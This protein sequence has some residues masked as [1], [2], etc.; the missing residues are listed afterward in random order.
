MILCIDPDEDARAATVRAFTEAGFEA[1]GVASAADARQSLRERGAVDALV[2][3]YDL[4]DGTGLELVNDSRELS[5]DTAC[6]LFTAVSLDDIDTEA[7]GGAVADYVSKDDPDARTEV[8]DRVEQSVAF[9]TQTS[10]PLPENE[11]ARVA[12][13]ERYAVDP[14]ALGG[15]IDRLAELATALF[16][17]DS[18]TVGVLDAHEQRF[19]SCHG[20]SFDTTDREETVCTYAILDDEVTV[21]EDTRDDPRFGDNEGLAAA[22]IRF[23]ASAPLVTPEGH[24]IGTFCIYDSEPRE[25]SEQDRHHLQ[26]FASEVM[27]QLTLRRRLQN[28]DEPDD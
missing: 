11:P 24:R 4:P 2:A 20:V 18:A 9:Q 26:L 17:V 6:V 23:Y 14:A 16:G 25:V 27:E 13:L 5:P 28:E 3:E 12:A 21:F 10:Y 22:N 7:F 19:L 15:T 8:V 1:R